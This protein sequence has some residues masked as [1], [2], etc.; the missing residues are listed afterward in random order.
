V[1][2]I[3]ESAQSA[4]SSR[5]AGAKVATKDWLIFVDSDVVLEF[6]WLENAHK[7]VSLGIF[8]CF[9]SC[10]KPS[11]EN[12]F[13]HNFR[14]QKTK[15]ITKNTFSHLETSGHFFPI[16]NTAACIYERKKFMSL[17]TFDSE[18]KAHEDTDLS[19]RYLNAGGHICLIDNA[20]S[21]VFWSRGI[22]QYIL[23]NYKHGQQARKFFQKWNS[24]SPLFNN[25]D[26]SSA[27]FTVTQRLFQKLIDLAY[28]AGYKLGK[29]YLN[30]NNHHLSPKNLNSNIASPQFKID[31][32]S[33][34]LPL[35]GRII[36]KHNHILIL[37]FIEKKSVSIANNKFLLGINLVIFQNLNEDETLALKEILIR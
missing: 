27:N 30:I 3:Y 13:L 5:N 34:Y 21:E 31:Q 26:I 18:L 15:K 12:T 22:L 35:D 24:N 20:K 16:V 1:K 37:Q 23:R 11:G 14:H 36:K 28:F 19:V 17:G 25:K 8:K 9:S 6:N 4:A 32:K 29:K 2:I 7:A 10:I 33:Y